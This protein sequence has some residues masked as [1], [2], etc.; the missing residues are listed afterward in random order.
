MAL[1]VQWNC[2]KR[3]GVKIVYKLYKTDKTKILQKSNKN[4]L[5]V[6]IKF[7]VLV[8]CNPVCIEV[9]TYVIVTYISRLQDTATKNIYQILKIYFE[10]VVANWWIRYLSICGNISYK[11][12]VIKTMKWIFYLI[13]INEFHKWSI[14]KKYLPWNISNAMICTRGNSKKKRDIKFNRNRH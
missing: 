7:P 11:V 14:S 8:R 1:N 3:D 10:F 6:N 2:K 5:G 4:I 12:Y 13:T 9:L